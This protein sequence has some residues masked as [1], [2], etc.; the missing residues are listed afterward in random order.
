MG[1]ATVTRDSDT[2]VTIHL[3]AR[4]KPSGEDAHETDPLPTLRITDVTSTEANLTKAFVSTAVNEA[5]GFVGFRETAIK[6][7][8]LIGRLRA[9]T[10]LAAA[11]VW[12]GPGEL[13]GDYGP[14]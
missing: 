4:Y 7:N 8:S 11:N 5:D 1:H 13:S 2:T 14:R 9:L 12:E 10:L 3:T 6:T